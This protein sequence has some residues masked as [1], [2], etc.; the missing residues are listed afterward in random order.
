VNAV[1]ADI[2]DSAEKTITALFGEKTA[3]CAT[4]FMLND[5]EHLARVWLFRS[6]YHGYPHAIERIV[7]HW[8]LKN[9]F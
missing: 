9:R 5:M 2:M 7:K 1:V 6:L 4:D 8:Q 3:K